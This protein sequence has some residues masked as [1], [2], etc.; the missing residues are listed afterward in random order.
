MFE[1]SDFFQVSNSNEGD[2]TTAGKEVRGK[3]TEAKQG[4]T[5]TATATV[6]RTPCRF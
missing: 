4:K 5:T 6:F 3:T 1:V 2:K